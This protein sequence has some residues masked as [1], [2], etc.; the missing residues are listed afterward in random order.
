MRTV[1]FFRK[2]LGTHLGSAVGEQQEQ[3]WCCHCPTAPEQSKQSQRVAAAR[4]IQPAIVRHRCSVRGWS[5]KCSHQMWARHQMWGWWL[6][7][8]GASGPLGGMR[9]T[10]GSLVRSWQQQLRIHK[11]DWQ[12]VKML[13]WGDLHQ[14]DLTFLPSQKW[15]AASQQPV[16][17][18]RIRHYYPRLKI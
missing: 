18:H 5:W 16:V 8:N 1:F 15:V 11:A 14:Y 2:L 12:Q 13:L 17:P 6:S 10:Q 9:G 7:Q 3:P 4:P